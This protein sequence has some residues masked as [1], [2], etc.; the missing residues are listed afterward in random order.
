MR[1][2]PSLRPRSLSGLILLGFAVVALPLLLGTI[3]AAVEM[4]NLAAASERL[5]L[6]GVAA[7]Q[8]TQA[9]VRQVSSLERTARL[10]QILRRPGL[11]ETFEQNRQLF[12]DTLDGLE[13]LPGDPDRASLIDEMRARTTRIGT[14]LASPEPA[15]VNAALREFT[16]L[17]K[18]AGRLSRLATQQTDR[19]LKQLRAETDDAR[20]RLFWQS[21]ALIPITSGLILLVTLFLARPIRQIDAAIADIGHGRLDEPVAVKGPSDLEALG[22]QL[23][24]LRERL[25]EIAEERNRFLR[26]MSHELKTPLANIREGSELLV[27]G[28]VGQLQG[29]QREIA[30]ILRE[31]SLQLQRLIENLLSYSEWQSKRSELELTEF[32]LPPLVKSAIDTY[33]LPI[34]AHRLNLELQVE[35]VA[36]TA[37]RAKLRLILDNLVSNAVKF[38]PEEGTIHV[39]ARKDDGH[40]VIERRRHRSRHRDGRARTDLRGVLPGRNAPGRPGARYRHRTVSRAGVRAGARRHDRGGGR[41]VPRG[42]LQGAVAGTDERSDARR[43]TQDVGARE[44][45]TLEEQW[46][47]ERLCKRIGETVA[48]IEGGGV[49]TL[50]EMPVG[51]AR[52]VSLVTVDRRE[53]D[54]GPG[55]Q[56]IEIADGLRTV[57]RVEDD[58]AL[59]ERSDGHRTRA[60]CGERLREGRLLRLR[61]QDREHGRGVDHHQRGSP[62]SS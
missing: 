19:E 51:M 27:E 43:M 58:R 61:E 1:S 17:S 52:E 30:G 22:R 7:T 40:L 45:A 44:I 53:V 46:L 59:D 21:A 26:H 18:D 47:T 14:D 20:R 12:I 16:Q 3:N 37:D 8:Y 29:E 2:L 25:T 48:E 33:Q 5:V 49:P 23:E 62:C 35:D 10:H 50:A 34:N 11:L 24:W 9:I 57:A 31:N 41:R 36:L 32:R 56:E 54:L 39:R 55:Q 28:A 15:R 38:T 42:A 13:K 6:N 60:V 4:R